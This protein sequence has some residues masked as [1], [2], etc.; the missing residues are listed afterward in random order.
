MSSQGSQWEGKTGV[1]YCLAKHGWI[2]LELHK[3]SRRLENEVDLKLLSFSKL[4]SNY[5]QRDSRWRSV[6]TNPAV[7][8]L[9]AIWVMS[10]RHFPVRAWRSFLH[11]SRSCCYNSIVFFSSTDSHNT[12]VGG[13]GHVFDT[14]ALEIAQLLSKV[15]HIEHIKPLANIKLYAFIVVAECKWEFKWVRQWLSTSIYHLSYT[16][17]AQ[18]N[19]SRL[20][21][22]I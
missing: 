2:Y 20:Q 21:A 13:S 19:S 4:G 5:T 14:M 11:M 9:C 7:L 15:L 18:R 1:S 10:W 3:E 8:F 6:Y 22:G 12:F 17:T 16:A